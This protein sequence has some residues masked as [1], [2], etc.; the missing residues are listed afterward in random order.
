MATSNIFDKQIKNRNFLSP[1]GFKF[2]LNR[3]PKQRDIL[4]NYFAKY[5]TKK[6]LLPAIIL[7]AL[8]YAFGLWERSP[9]IDDAWLGE[10]AYWMAEDGYCHSELMRGLTLQEERF[11]VHHKLFNL[12]G[13]LFVKMFGYSLPTLK[14]V[15]LVYFFLFIFYENTIHYTQIMSIYI[16]CNT[17]LQVFS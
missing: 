6:Y 2:T 7:F 12:H 3:A 4:M 13:A 16:I 11:L 8:V 1:T 15:T 10:Y 17:S 14:S 9:D 5:F